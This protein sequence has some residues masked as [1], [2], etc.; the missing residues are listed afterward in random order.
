MELGMGMWEVEV[1][2]RFGHIVRRAYE[3]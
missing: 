2:Q 3:K 1:L